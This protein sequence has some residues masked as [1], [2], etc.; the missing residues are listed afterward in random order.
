MY[1]DGFFA[2]KENEN[3]F[4]HP[5]HGISEVRT[6][7]G[8]IQ[9]AGTGELIATGLINKTMPVI[10]YV[11]GDQISLSERDTRGRVP[12]NNL[13]G[14]IDDVIYSTTGAPVGRLDPIFKGG[15]GIKY[16]QIYQDEKGLVELRIVPDST[17]K[18]LNGENLL[19]ELKKRVGDDT[20]TKLVI[21]NSLDKGKN[22]KFRP[23]IS[24]YRPR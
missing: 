18:D 17:Y 4:F 22:G 6:E 3:F 14:R 1:R 11:V 19:Y 13:I 16:A 15:S 24:Q 21:L 23:V 20:P 7:S 8:H 5:E 10:R 12:I 9:N 2:T